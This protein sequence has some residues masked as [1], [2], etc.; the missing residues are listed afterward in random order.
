MWFSDCRVL[1]LEK[2]VVCA[3]ANNCRNVEQGNC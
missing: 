3:V 2:K 1:V